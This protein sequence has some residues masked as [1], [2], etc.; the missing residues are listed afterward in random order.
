M[1]NDVTDLFTADGVL[2]IG[3]VGS[4]TVPPISAA[5]SNATARPVSHAGK[6]NDHPLFD[7]MIEIAPGGMEARVRGLDWGMLGDFSSGKAEW[8]VRVFHNRFVKQDGVW[9]IREMR[10]FPVLKTDYYQGWG[11][12]RARRTEQVIPAFLP[13]PVTGKP[14]TYPDGAKVVAKDRLRPPL[15]ATA[16]AAPS[17]DT[18]CPHRRGQRKLAVSKAYDG[19]ENIT[20]RVHPLHR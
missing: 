4:T 16:S 9:K 14:V 19:A 20:S 1:W 13:D 2:E 8:S 11:K 10:L 6:L 3:G 15:R 7:T 12:S 17:G 5:R 18:R